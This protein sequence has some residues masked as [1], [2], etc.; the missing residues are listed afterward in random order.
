MPTIGSAQA[1]A[2]DASIE[3]ARLIIRLLG[4]PPLLITEDLDSYLAHR[5]YLLDLFQPREPALVI[6]V[7][8]YAR[9][10]WEVARYDRVMA[11]IVRLARKDALRA[12][13]TICLPD[14]LVGLTC[15]QL[16]DEWFK[17]ADIKKQILLR[18]EVHCIDEG[19]ITAKATSMRLDQLSELATLRDKAEADAGALLREIAFYKSRE[20]SAPPGRASGYA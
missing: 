4:P 11:S 20:E 1:A 12:I 10:M 15:D 7:E 9:K 8:R 5:G 13:L 14:G 2:S 3:Q 19:S 16:A 17:N 6:A 18:L